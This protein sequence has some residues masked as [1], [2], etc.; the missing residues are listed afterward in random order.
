MR[1]LIDTYLTDAP[2]LFAEMRTALA[3]KDA[4]TF[5]AQLTH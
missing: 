4:E 3:A 5:R 2:G 1:E